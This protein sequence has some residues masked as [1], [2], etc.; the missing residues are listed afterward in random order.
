[1]A[2]WKF[3][4]FLLIVNTLM[5]VSYSLLTYHYNF[6]DQH[7]TIDMI[8][9]R[10]RIPPI[11]LWVRHFDY[12]ISN[13]L[14][15]LCVGICILHMLNILCIYEVLRDTVLRMETSSYKSS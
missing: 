10:D 13:Y 7:F 15:I 14:L 11:L 3:N 5:I 6:R 4:I 2:S 8:L 12:N 9:D 1:M